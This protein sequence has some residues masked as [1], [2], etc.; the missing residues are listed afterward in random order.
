SPR[1]PQRR[2]RRLA[3]ACSSASASGVWKGLV[4]SSPPPACLLSAQRAAAFGWQSEPDLGAIRNRVFSRCDNPQGGSILRFDHVVAT[5]AEKH[6]PYHNGLHGIGG[7][8]WHFR[9]KLD[10]VLADSDYG[11]LAGLKFRAHHLQGRAGKRDMVFVTRGDVDHIAGADEARDEF[12]LWPV[13][14]ILGRA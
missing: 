4:F 9:R 13:V 5:C 11:F 12:R 3:P 14:N 7:R 6:L 1:G 10:V 2:T 8:Q